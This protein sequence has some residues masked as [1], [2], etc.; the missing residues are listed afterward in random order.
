M[1]MRRSIENSDGSHRKFPF[2]RTID[3]TQIPDV[4]TQVSRARKLCS[5]IH[6]ADEATAG[7]QKKDMRHEGQDRKAGEEESR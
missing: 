1:H 5:S 2:V 3:S 6:P 4:T 7:R